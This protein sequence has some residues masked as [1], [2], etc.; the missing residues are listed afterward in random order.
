[1]DTFPYYPTTPGM[2]RLK[3]VRQA[4]TQYEVGMSSGLGATIGRPLRRPRIRQPLTQA[5]RV[6]AATI[7]QPLPTSPLKL[8][9]VQQCQ[10][11]GAHKLGFETA[12]FCC[13]NGTIELP[14]NKYPSELIRLYTGN[15]D[16]ALHFQ[17]YARLYNNLFAFSSIGGD[18]DA[19]THKGTME[20]HDKDDRQISCREYYCYKLQNRPSNMMLRAGRCFQQYVVDMYVKIENTRLD[21][22]R[23]NQDTIRAELYQG[24]LDTVDAGECCVAN[25]GRR[26][27]LPPTYI[28]GPCDMKKRYLNAMALVQKYGKPDLFITM[29]CNANWPEI[30]ERLAPGELSQNRPDLVAR[31]FRA[32]LLAL[33][34]KI[35]EDQV[36]G[37]VAAF[38]YVVE[39]QKRGLPHAHFLII[40]K[41][42]YKMKGTTDYDK[43]VSA[44]IP[45]PS[46]AALHASVL[47]HMMHGPCGELNREC[48]CMNHKNT[49][50][51]CKYNYPKSFTDETTNNSE[52]YPV[53]RRRDDGQ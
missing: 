28:G 16:D 52:G 13:G 27:I 26:V 44:E 41:P 38:I 31:V 14:H 51:R 23:N 7:G 47:K 45:P 22:F 12:N 39:F 48:S 10:K 11:C 25:V 19:Q 53:Y 49:M 21:F 24:I 18:F 1:M 50:G 30:Q 15:T 29:T 3:R 36:F 34:K 9:Q 32:K 40:L 42:A 6:P 20:M 5:E 8:P 46:C 35:T 4:N 43:F 2:G 37:E 17:T 33:K